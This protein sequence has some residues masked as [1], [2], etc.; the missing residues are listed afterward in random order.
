MAVD[1]CAAPLAL[2]YT[3]VVIFMGILAH[4]VYNR[5]LTP[6]KERN[7]AI[8][9]IIG[10]L[11]MWN[12]IMQTIPMMI[13]DYNVYMLVWGPM[14]PIIAIIMGY[15]YKALVSGVSVCESE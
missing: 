13:E 10:C 14:L 7:P 4:Y 6:Y 1:G 15:L 2:S 9:I 8:S 5:N 12:M 11:C 3:T